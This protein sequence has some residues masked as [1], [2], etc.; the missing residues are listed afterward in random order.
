MARNS[1]RGVL[2]T[3]LGGTENPSERSGLAA[4]THDYASVLEVFFKFRT[5]AMLLLPQWIVRFSLVFV[6]DYP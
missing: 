3:Q 2:Q 6:S 4:S 1:K 5:K